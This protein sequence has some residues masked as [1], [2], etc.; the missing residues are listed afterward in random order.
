MYV[1]EKFH[2]THNKKVIK[3]A[4]SATEW[5]FDNRLYYQQD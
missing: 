5:N 4:I 2:N 3:S 1:H